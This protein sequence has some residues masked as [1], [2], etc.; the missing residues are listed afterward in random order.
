MSTRYAELSSAT[1]RTAVG[2]AF[3]ALLR[4]AKSERG[5]SLY[6]RPFESVSTS[7]GE[8]RRRWPGTENSGDTKSEGL[9]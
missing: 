8:E 2:R 6:C 4:P 1:L 3:W 7:R 9:G 5:Q